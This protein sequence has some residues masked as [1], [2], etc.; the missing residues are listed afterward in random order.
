M[1]RKLATHS[2]NFVILYWAKIGKIKRRIDMKTFIVTILA[3]DSLPTGK[4]TCRTHT[5]NCHS[6]NEAKGLIMESLSALHPTF[7][8][9][10]MCFGY[11]VGVSSVDGLIYKI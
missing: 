8:N 1:L 4:Y 11:E 2:M 9:I 10:K 3:D 7:T 6:L 5:Y